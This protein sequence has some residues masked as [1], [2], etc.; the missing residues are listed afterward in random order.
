MLMLMWVGHTFSLC[1]LP[2]GVMET[3]KS[4]EFR[5]VLRTICSNFV[6]KI[7]AIVT[8]TDALL[9]RLR[10]GDR[11]IIRDRVLVGFCVRMNIKRRTFMVA[12]T[13]AGKQVRAVIGFYPLMTT[14]EARVIATEIIKQCRA[15]TYSKQAPRPT[16]TYPS[17]REMLP[18]YI[19]DKGLKAPT[20]RRYDSLMRTH[21]PDW[22]DKPVNELS[23][24]LF[25]EHCH[26]F[27]QTQTVSVTEMGR[28]FIGAITRYVNA[29]FGMN[30][31]SPFIRLAAAGLM[32]EKVQPRKR[33]L[34]ESRLPE[35]YQAV[36]RL[37]DQQRDALLLIAMTGLRRSE[38][39]LM[40]RNQVNF[41]SG[42]I[43]IP[44]TKTGKAHSLPITPVLEEILNRRCS[45]LQPED[46][47]FS[48]VSGEHLADRAQRH[49][50]PAFMLHDLRKLLA[51][52]GERLQIAESILRRILNHT[53]KRSD[54]LYRHYVSIELS[55]I[56][57]P[58]EQ[59]QRIL[60]K[61][62]TM[63]N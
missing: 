15:G 54:T 32:N 50:A 48:S 3:G 20:Q 24:P 6:P 21:F 42:I 30:I 61:L 62:M 41:G 39:L 53:S 60:L 27:V 40:R 25:A 14:A 23:S 55:D 36:N 46:L 1:S 9:Q 35:W 13:C 5:T 22:Y 29:I 43:S 38:A 16:T 8:L 44:E 51:T 17:I 59:I 31:T 56:S 7:M 63:K 10:H 26:K 37:P 19:K 2:C 52:I 45:H 49:G 11:R 28:A 4:D 47:L 18:Q 12:T 34:E 57:A 58:L 33:R